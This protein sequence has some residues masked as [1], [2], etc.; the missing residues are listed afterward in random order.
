MGEQSQ[1]TVNGE[2]RRN[3]FR[4]PIQNASFDGSTLEVGLLE[5]G[6][7]VTDRPKASRRFFAK[8]FDCSYQG[9]RLLL[10]PHPTFK[11]PLLVGNR[12]RMSVGG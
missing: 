4:V 2:E 7:I 3:Q 5:S 6:Q 8:L 9:V 1:N 11:E 12:L 10:T